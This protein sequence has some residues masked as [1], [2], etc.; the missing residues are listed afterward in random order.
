LTGA[1]AINGTGNALNNTQLAM[2]RTIPEWWRRQRHAGW[3]RGA[4]SLVGG[5]GDDSYVVDNTG[6]TVVEASGGGTDTV[7]SR[8][9]TR[10]RPRSG[11]DI[12]RRGG[13]QH[14][15]YPQQHN[16]GNSANNVLTGS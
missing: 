15:Q 1:A 10:W 16:S 13:N 9:A 11:S 2:R 4:D 6:D 7:L 14:R 3:R 5:T 12:D 8:S